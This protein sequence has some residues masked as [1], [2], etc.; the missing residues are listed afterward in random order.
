ML[1]GTD[2]AFPPQESQ[3]ASVKLEEEVARLRQES[4]DWPLQSRALQAELERE[5]EERK[6][7]EEEKHTQMQREREERKVEVQKLTEHF[8]KESKVIL[9]SSSDPLPS[10]FSGCEH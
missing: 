1:C 8:Q 6:Q 3:Q 7:E 9:S 4:S 2:D 10:Y 5:R